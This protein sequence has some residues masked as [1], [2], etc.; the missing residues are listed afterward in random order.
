MTSQYSLP[1]VCSVYHATKCLAPWGHSVTI[2]ACRLIREAQNP[3]PKQA[4]AAVK[5]LAA[6]R[7]LGVHPR[8]TSHLRLLQLE[9]VDALELVA[10]ATMSQI[11]KCERDDKGR[12]YWAVELSIPH[13]NSPTGLLYVKPLLHLPSLSTGYILSF[14]ASTDRNA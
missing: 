9:P 6:S 10:A 2:T 12:P 3:T 4:L 8:C 7:R 5:A 14:K 13:V 11:V 1:G